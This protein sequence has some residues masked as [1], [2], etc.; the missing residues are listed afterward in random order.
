[1]FRKLLGDRSEARAARELRRRG[2]RIITRNFSCPAGEVD[3][4]ARSGTTL[5]FV[6]VRSRTTGDVD[7]IETIDAAKQ[8]RICRA[9]AAYVARTPGS[10][11]DIRFD[12]VGITAGVL[13][14]IEGAFD[15]GDM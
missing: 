12:V 6:E 10:Y 5:V 14:V 2:Y 1:V 7:A 9:A 11:T 4:V 3:I 13:T 8:R 15:S